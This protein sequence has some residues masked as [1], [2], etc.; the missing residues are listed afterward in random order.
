VSVTEQDSELGPLAPL[1]PPSSP[2]RGR[3]RSIVII[4][5]L[6]VA[7]SVLLS[8]G[9]LHNLNYFET[10]NQ[11]MKQMTSLGNRDFRLEGVVAPGTITRSANGA[12]FFLE[13][14]V[15]HE[16]LVVAT[17]Q[18]PQ[19]FQSNIPVVVDGHFVTPTF[20]RSVVFDAHQIIVKHSAN[21]IA[22]HP[23]R[24]KAPNGTSR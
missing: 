22:Q 12:T 4:V 16:I 3:R 8:Q 1:A 7:V 14:K 23:G 9:L 11:A 15:P 18:P 5:T 17:G 6:V 13:G 19:L 10:V 21:Y 20:G 2:K 24:V